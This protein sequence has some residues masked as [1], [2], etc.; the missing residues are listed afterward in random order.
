M[1]SVS[2]EGWASTS[3]FPTGRVTGTIGEA[4]EIAAETQALL[5]ANDVDHGEFPQEVI[6]ELE[7]A[8]GVTG[9]TMAPIA[10]VGAVKGGG[11]SLGGGEN[12]V[13][14]QEEIAKVRDGVIAAA[15]AAAAAAH[16][17]CTLLLHIAACDP[18]HAWPTKARTIFKCAVLTLGFFNAL[19]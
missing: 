16:C 2:L 18:L 3:N 14:P 11:R 13:I 7:Q 4:G 8:Y 10:G 12:W 9:P 17:C 19:K 6:A 5:T 15:A 1:F